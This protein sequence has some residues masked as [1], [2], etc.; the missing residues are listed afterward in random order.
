M[1]KFLL[2]TLSVLLI[3]VSLAGC[4]NDNR[5]EGTWQTKTNMAEDFNS[6]LGDEEE[7]SQYLKV[8]E[9]YIVHYI[10]FNSDGT[11]SQYADEEELKKTMDGLK[12]HLRSGLTE[13]YE[14]EI[15][16]NQLNITVDELLAYSELTMDG[17]IEQFITQE[18]FDEMVE[19]FKGEGNYLAADGQLHMSESLD[20]VIDSDVYETYTV[21]GDTFSITGQGGDDYDETLEKYYPVEYVKVK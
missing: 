18:M 13:Y 12:E 20:T 16:K 19:G 2:M 1:K 15:D 11:Y 17:L 14:Y 5:L 10:T 7:I 21:D 4:L 6:G 8:D 9:F 3:I